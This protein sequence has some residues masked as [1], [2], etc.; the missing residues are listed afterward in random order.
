MLYRNKKD[1]D[2]NA[3]KWIGVGGKLMEGESPDECL[4]REVKEETGLSLLRYRFR[5]IV[6]FVSDEWG[7]EQMFLYTSDQFEGTLTECAEGELRWIN[8][9]HV[10]DLPLWEGD[11]HFLK[12]LN[13][14]EEV[15]FLKLQYE[16]DTLV[17]VTHFPPT[18]ERI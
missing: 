8:R 7:T 18:P 5:G 3:G 9:E 13:E 14:T 1:Q 16:G 17:R 4:L 2:E 10:L 12:L 6:T 11:R 15:F